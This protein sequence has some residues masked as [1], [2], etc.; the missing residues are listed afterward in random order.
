MTPSIENTPS[1]AIILK[2]APLAS[3]NLASRSVMLLFLKRKRCALQRRMPSMIDAWLSSSEMTASCSPSN[4][5][6]NPP[7][8]SKHD[9]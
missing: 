3:F 4:V 1:V 8:A 6:N 7:F 5:S 9:E 2:R